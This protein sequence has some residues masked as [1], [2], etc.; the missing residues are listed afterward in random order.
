MVEP[1]TRDAYLIPRAHFKFWKTPSLLFE[2]YIYSMKL[3]CLDMKVYKLNCY[4][5]FNGNWAI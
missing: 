5:V 4:F 1:K 2:D 3:L